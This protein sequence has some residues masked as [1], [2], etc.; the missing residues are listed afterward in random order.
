MFSLDILGA[1]FLQFMVVLCSVLPAVYRCSLRS[2]AP[3]HINL[4]S[5]SVRGVS[6]LFSASL[7]KLCL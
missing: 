2:V 5:A 4:L 7:P 3:K 1:V 6:L